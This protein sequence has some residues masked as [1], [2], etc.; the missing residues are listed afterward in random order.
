[1]RLTPINSR[2]ED[3]SVLAQYYINYY[4]KTIEKVDLK[5]YT[6]LKR[7]VWEYNVH[8]LIHIVKYLVL[9]CEEDILTSQYVGSCM[10]MLMEGRQKKSTSDLLGDIVTESVTSLK[11]AINTFKS[12]YTYKKYNT[13]LFT[14]V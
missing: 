14:D 13:S 10:F 12:Q 8:S 6:I 3:L 11:D 9:N 1:M 4:H 5:V 2:L 7:Y